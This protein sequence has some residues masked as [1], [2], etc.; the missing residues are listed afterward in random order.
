MKCVYVAVKYVRTAMFTDG[1][2]RFYI[3][4]LC[5]R[6]KNHRDT[7]WIHQKYT[8]SRTQKRPKIGKKRGFEDFFLTGCQDF[9]RQK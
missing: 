7:F 2:E 3:P 8:L 9:V 4:G 6:G 1:K 5:G